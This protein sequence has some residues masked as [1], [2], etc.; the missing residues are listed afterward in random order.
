MKKLPV[1]KN[2]IKT[3]INKNMNTYNKIII[4]TLLYL[5]IML[6]GCGNSNSEDDHDET[7]SEETSHEENEE[8]IL[9]KESIETIG[10][11]ISEI[12]K[13]T[14]SGQLTA[15]AVVVTNQNLE[16]LVGSLIEGRV[17]R[18]FANV[19]DY[20]RKGN[21][22]MYIEGLEIGE[23]KSTYIKAKANLEFFEAALE[24]QRTL[25]E[26][27]VGSKRTFLEAKAEY[28][29][30]LAE[31]KAED[32]RLHSVGFTEYDIEKFLEEDDH[33]AGRIPIRSPISGVIIERNVVVGQSIDL[34][35]TAFKIINISTV[36]VDGQVFEKDIMKLGD[37]SSIQF[38]STSVPDVIFEGRISYIGEVIDESTRTLKVRASINNPNHLLKPQMYGEMKIPTKDNLKGLFVKNEAIVKEEESSFV[39]VLI[40]DTTFKK[41]KIE[42][43]TEID[44]LVEV[45]RGL[46]EGSKIVTKGSFLLNAE[47]LKD[48]FGD[49]HG[50]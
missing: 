35:S 38:T 25:Y 45:V 18:V 31:F 37:K 17:S 44:G 26:Q 3:E 27:N 4:L 7:E 9:S 1:I 22:L 30:A 11:E 19:G 49:E 32:K 29:K 15:P 13:Q 21:V 39:F 12:V 14:M 28:E 8:V 16:V 6:N 5:S 43:G 40:N 20:V 41:E 48:S 23:I 50:H 47:L 34:S 36:W 24:R 10:L 2:K 33:S 42:I 46:S